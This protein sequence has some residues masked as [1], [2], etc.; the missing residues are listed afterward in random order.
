MATTDERLM[1]RCVGNLCALLATMDPV[2]RRTALKQLLLDVDVSLNDLIESPEFNA[3]TAD[4]ECHLIVYHT[5]GRMTLPQ[6][7]TL[8]ALAPLPY[9]QSE[10]EHDD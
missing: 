9:D 8:H 5:I 1:G 7:R 2:Q 3:L 6:L 10:E 4:D